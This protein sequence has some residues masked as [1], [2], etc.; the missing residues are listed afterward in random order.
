M[1]NRDIG[2]HADVLRSGIPLR[3]SLPGI[4]G[5]LLL[6]AFLFV[7]PAL[8]EEGQTASGSA[9]SPSSSSAQ[10]TDASSAPQ[11]LVAVELSCTSS[12]K[13]ILYDTPSGHLDAGYYLGDAS[14]ST[15]GMTPTHTMG[16]GYWTICHDARGHQHEFTLTEQEYEALMIRGTPQRSVM[17]SPADA[18]LD[19]FP[20]T[21]Q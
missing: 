3:Y 10:V 12:Y 13:G 1:E 7:H 16:W 9:V 15:T 21:D 2:H 19:A 14:A 4:F 20:S 6:F 11:N 18:A 17:E 8:A 5:I